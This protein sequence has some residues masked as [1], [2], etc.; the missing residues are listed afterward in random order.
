[1]TPPD[2]HPLAVFDLRDESNAYSEQV[3]SV[4]VMYA[5]L[6]VLFGGVFLW[7]VGIALTEGVVGFGWVIITVVLLCLSILLGQFCLLLWKTQPGAISVTV[8]S[9]GIEFTWIS[10]RADF[11]PWSKVSR[12]LALRDH[13]GDGTVRPGYYWFARRWN[14]PITRLSKAAFDAIIQAAAGDGLGPR[15]QS[16]R[17]TPFNWGTY[18]TVRFALRVESARNR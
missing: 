7:F 8:R 9:Q 11:L 3:R 17:P 18:R 10:G 14:R 2:Q 1:M 16:H 13:S 15:D 6:T 5:F 12:D 4:R